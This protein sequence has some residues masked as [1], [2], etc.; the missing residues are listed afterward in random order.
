ME[1]NSA[2]QTAQHVDKELTS[3]LAPL[4][5]QLNE[6]FYIKA[7]R[8]PKGISEFLVLIAPYFT[9]IGAIFL[10]IALIV[11]MGVSVISLPI[12]AFAA[13]ATVNPMIYLI[14]SIVSLLLSIASIPGLF[15]RSKMGWNFMFYGVLWSALI[16][17]VSVN[18][19]SLIISLVISFY[20]LFQLRPFYTHQ[21]A[22][23]S[24]SVGN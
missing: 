5:K 1:N 19:V 3:F 20:F 4:E 6:W 18:V 10:T 24:K 9:I 22:A 7:P 13:P 15:A 8:L 2:Q 17:L 12:W 23:P 14:L 21:L 11:M 16:N